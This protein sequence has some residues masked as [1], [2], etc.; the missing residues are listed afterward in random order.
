[1]LEMIQKSDESEEILKII[2]NYYSLLP[3]NKF[4]SLLTIS[5]GDYNL[6][7]EGDE[8][9]T[10]HLKSNKKIIPDVIF[11]NPNEIKK[12][13]YRCHRKK[14]QIK[15]KITKI[16]TSIEENMEKNLESEEVM[17][18]DKIQHINMLNAT[19]NKNS[20]YDMLNYFSSPK[21]MNK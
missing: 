17:N 10:S 5:V 18:E 4:M 21:A 16:S 8:N 13:T 1:M 9:K 19:V 2:K 12:Q 6:Y 11:K 7:Y 20:K 14:K 3:F 15:P